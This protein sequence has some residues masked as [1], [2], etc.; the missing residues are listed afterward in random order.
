M[1]ELGGIAGNEG[2]GRT[3][4][5][6]IAASSKKPT[7]EAQSPRCP[8]WALTLIVWLEAAAIRQVRRIPRGV[9]VGVE[10]ARWSDG[11]SAQED[12]RGGIV[13]PGMQVGEARL[14]V[15]SLVDPAAGFHVARRVIDLVAVGTIG[16]SQDLGSGGVRDRLD[17]AQPVGVEP[18]GLR[19]VAGAHP[20]RHHAQAVDRHVLR[21]LPGGNF[22]V[23][24]ERVEACGAPGR[25]LQPLSRF[26][27]RKLRRADL[28]DPV[29]GVP[30]RRPPPA[31]DQVPVRVVAVDRTVDVARGMR[32][33]G[34]RE[35]ILVGPD[36]GSCS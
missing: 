21:D 33:W 23:V 13:V 11:I 36:P 6:T 27:V 32:P 17:A 35:R 4:I 24:S 26:V 5:V 22:V 7:E 34:T 29:L 14:A 31:V 1:A 30:D 20:L 9:A 12:P 3:P 2:T 28:G 16:S 19:A 15:L 25:L 18:E 8:P 10:S